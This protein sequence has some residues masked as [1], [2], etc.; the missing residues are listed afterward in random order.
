[1]KASMPQV[2]KVLEAVIW[3]FDTNRDFMPIGS[4]QPEVFEYTVKMR[5]GRK[6]QRQTRGGREAAQ[7]RTMMKAANKHTEMMMMWCRQVHGSCKHATSEGLHAEKWVGLIAST[8]CGL[9]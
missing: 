9:M 6:R 3:R 7:A 4:E 8:K 1:M 2:R 5:R